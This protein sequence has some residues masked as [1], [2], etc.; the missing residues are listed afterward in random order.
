[1]QVCMTR[2]NT[3]GFFLFSGLGLGFFNHNL[4]RKINELYQ[5]FPQE[6]N[7]WTEIYVKDFYGTEKLLKECPN[8][9]LHGQNVTLEI[10]AHFVTH[11]KKTI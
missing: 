2:T 1:M 8:T 3:K 11:S 5:K 7:P 4:P 9:S 10:C 6:S